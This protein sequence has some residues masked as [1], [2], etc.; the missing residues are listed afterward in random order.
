L[1][2]SLDLQPGAVINGRQV[3]HRLRIVPSLRQTDDDVTANSVRPD[4][5]PPPRVPVVRD[6]APEQIEVLGKTPIGPDGRPLNLFLTLA[7]HP[8]LLKRFNVLAGSFFQKSVLPAADREL[9]ILRVA[10]SCGS[11]YEFEQHARIAIECGLTQDDVE[12]L[13]DGRV[14]PDWGERRLALVAFTDALLHDDAVTDAIWDAVPFHERADAM[15]ELTCLIGFYRMVAVFL[16]V[17]RVELE[18]HAVVDA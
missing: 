10:A 14:S 6:L 4:K 17:T 9:V 13:R 12:T 18:D 3:L 8:R 7:H 11:D 1:V 5:L 2:V 15:I 16:N